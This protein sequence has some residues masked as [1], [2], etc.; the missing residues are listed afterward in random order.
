MNNNTTSG[1]KC[2]FCLE[3]SKA[4]RLLIEAKIAGVYICYECAQLSIHVIEEECK[5]RGLPAPVKEEF[6]T[7]EQIKQFIADNEN[8]LRVNP[9]PGEEI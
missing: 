1:L 7:N 3:P 9:A 5:R 4:T 6:W 8:K 2:A